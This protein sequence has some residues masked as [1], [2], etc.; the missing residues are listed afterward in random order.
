M[1]VDGKPNATN[2]C[3]ITREI[4][5]N[6]MVTTAASWNIS[7]TMCEITGEGGLWVLSVD[8]RVVDGQPSRYVM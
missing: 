2:A 1:S 7:G 3:H 8:S 4:R 6:I 5:S